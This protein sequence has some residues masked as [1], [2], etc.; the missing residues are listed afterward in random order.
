MTFLT[1]TVTATFLDSTGRPQRG[2]RVTFNLI[3][4]H[5]YL[6]ADREF[7]VCPPEVALL[8][9]SDGKLSY[10]LPLTTQF[11]KRDSSTS[12]VQWQV[13]LDSVGGLGQFVLSAGSPVELSQLLDGLPTYT[14]SGVVTLGG[15]PLASVAVALSGAASLSATT[16]AD[17][18]FSFPGLYP[19]AYTLT[20]TREGYTF[21]P[22]SSD[23]TLSADTA[24]NFTAAHATATIHGVVQV[25]GSP[26]AG[27]TV[28]LGGDASAT[29]TTDGA[30][31]YSFT[32]EQGG[33][34]V[35]TPS[36][37]NYAFTP[38]SQGFL[39]VFED[40]VLDFTAIPT[41]S[42][43]FGD[44]LGAGLANELDNNT[45]FYQYL[46]GVEG[47]TVRSPIQAFGGA[48]LG[49]V[50]PQV[51][52][53][54]VL[55]TRSDN[56]VIEFGANDTRSHYVDSRSDDQYGEGIASYAAFL[57][58]PD[59]QKARGFETSKI[60]YG[61][62]VWQNQG[63]NF[64][65][66]MALNYSPETG[67][68]TACTAQITV[69]GTAVYIGVKMRAAND[70]ATIIVTIDGVA[71]APITLAA[72][73]GQLAGIYVQDWD[74]A[75]KLL[76]FGGLSDGA[77][78]V[79]ISTGTTPVGV[80][81][82]LDWISGNKGLTGTVTPSNVWVM[83]A[84]QQKDSAAYALNGGSLARTTA[85]GVKVT[86]LCT[87]LRGD[88]LRVFPVDPNPYLNHS[89]DYNASDGLHWNV[90][91]HGH[92]KDA[93]VAAIVANP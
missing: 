47:W 44:S 15:A 18:A 26:L 9:D 80:P 60:T 63:G 4:S 49:D 20:P 38:N 50:E 1:R 51:F 32:V 23:V 22:S 41:Q 37:P 75:P 88:G 7:V 28:T 19:G 68:Q 5:V 35:I 17:G 48:S 25:M 91:G 85:F 81:F 31:S 33:D 10:E 29:T 3:P 34:Y 64:V 42:Q 93:F 61:G 52:Q 76:R 14:L 30:G 36:K 77:H 73:S 58:L 69:H 11:T 27:V 12:P 65:G 13:A 46:S 72:P 82:Y 79:H 87:T 74:Y 57:S 39:D 62:G 43:I 24:Q 84:P 55:G 78:T 86:S 67:T 92:V 66:Y 70:P 89:T 83:L 6:D 71:Q 54:S 90:T 53:T 59:A 8:L 2:R 56:Y 21:S 40:G 16:D 45:S